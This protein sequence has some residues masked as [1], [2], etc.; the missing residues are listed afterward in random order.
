MQ[1]AVPHKKNFQDDGQNPLGD[2]QLGRHGF[3]NHRHQFVDDV[4][5]VLRGRRSRLDDVLILDVT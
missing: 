2:D 4:T 3:I 5:G 1:L